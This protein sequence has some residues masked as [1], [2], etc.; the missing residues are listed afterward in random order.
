MDN[1]EKISL[2][3]EGL[4]DQQKEAVTAGGGPLLIVAGAGTGKTTVI[5]KRVAYLIASGL[6]APNEIL[7]LTFTDKAAAEMEERVDMLVPYGCTQMQISTFHA[8]GDKILREHALEVGLN[9][10]FEVLTKPEQ[11]IFITEHLFDFPLDY[12]RPLSN[13]AQSVDALVTV[14]SRARDEDISP[15][16][17]LTYVERLKKSVAENQE[18]EA[19]QELFIQQREVANSFK[20]YQDLKYKN[21]KI[22]FGDQVSKALELLRAHPLLLS[23]YQDRFKY[24]LVDEFQD[25]NYAQFQLVKLLSSKYKNITVAADDDQSIYKFR[26]AAVSNI[27]NFTESYPEARL[28]SITKNYRSTQKILDSAYRLITHNNPE[29]LEIKKNIDKRLIGADNKDA[30]QPTHIHCDTV[31]TESDK[32]ASIIEEKVRSGQYEYKDFAILVRS[33]NDAD[34]FLR[35]LNMKS[36]PWRFSGNRGLYSRPEIRLAISFLKII[37]DAG[38]NLSLY[39][40]AGSEVYGL[41]MFNLSRIMAVSSRKNVSLFEI[42]KDMDKHP[43]IGAVSPQARAVIEKIVKD[44]EECLEFSRDE[45]SGR[46]LYKF[47]SDTTYL[48]RLI[49]KQSLSG[50]AKIQNLAKFFDRVRNFERLADKDRVPAFVKHLDM[51]INAGDDPAVVEADLDIPAVNVLTIHKAKGLEFKVVFLVSLVAQKFPSRSRKDRIELPAELIKDILP[52]GDFHIQEERRLFYVGMTRAREELYLTSAQDY[53]GK[54]LRKISQFITEA[55]GMSQEETMALK[56]SPLEVIERSAPVPDSGVF[57]VA[58]EMPDNQTL[59]LS[60][61]KIDDYFSCP[62][63]YKYVHV[64][65]VPVKEHHAVVYGKVIHDCVNF[66][67][68]NKISAKEI[69]LDGILDYYRQIWRSEGY[70]DKAHEGKRF[71]AGLKTLE[72]FFK[73]EEE[74]NILPSHLEKEF[75]I[76]IGFEKITGRFDRIDIINDKIYIIDYKTSLVKDKKDADKRTQQSMQMDIYALACKFMYDKLPAAVSLYFL[77][78]GVRGEAVKKEND[79]EKAVEKIKEVSIGIR[80][81]RFSA[82][83][84]YNACEW[85][86]YCQICPHTAY[87]TTV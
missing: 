23:K 51:L 27:L 86:A 41:D 20:I 1:N 46:V 65:R 56:A 81:Q 34:P 74:Q 14:F 40:L 25:T 36:I 31:S 29:R 35:A 9:P 58:G 24:I 55:L 32:I 66:Y 26:G 47:L 67:Y 16:E 37:A 84:K 52:E 54:R 59:S 60:W 76:N 30:L 87:K 85:C 49:E 28:I 83:P 79:L 48:K 72:D 19:L 61:R 69:T 8:F 17:Y 45:S 38:D 71:I 33:N 73:R 22:D 57:A 62:L 4:N 68:R 5:T 42:F 63:K 2:I 78:S 13:P 70:L 39:N 44:I 7:A 53:G 6:A 10:E 3:S 82:E 77:E 12:Y 80:Q 11:I 50:D 43:E 21:N 15:E 64:L 75:R 18:D